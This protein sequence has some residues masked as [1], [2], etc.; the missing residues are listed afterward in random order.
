MSHDPT[1]EEGLAEIVRDWRR[2]HQVSQSEL[3]R[4]LGCSQSL[5]NKVERG[6][7]RDWSR[8]ETVSLIYGLAEIFGTTAPDLIARAA[9]PARRGA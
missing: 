4:R 3:A 7:V 9:H 8:N 6:N 2:T 5:V 1:I